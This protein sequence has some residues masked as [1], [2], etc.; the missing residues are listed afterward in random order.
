[1]TEDLLA[2]WGKLKYDML[3]Q[4]V[5]I[6]ESHSS[7][8]AVDTEPIPPTTWCLLRQMQLESFYP[9]LSKI[10]DI[11]LSMPVSNAWPERGASAL[12][13]L[14]TRLRSS[15]RNDILQA[16]KHVSVNGAATSSPKAKAVIRSAVAEWLKRKPRRKLLRKTPKKTSEN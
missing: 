9:Q 6:L 13:R 7:D 2:E 5:D 12:K 8:S 15:I 14:K 1:M 10:A 16:L 11:L 3:N 4:K